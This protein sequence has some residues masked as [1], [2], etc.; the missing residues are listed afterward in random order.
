MAKLHKDYDSDEE[1]PDLSTIISLT[2]KTDQGQLPSSAAIC[3][4][5]QRNISPTRANDKPF[6]GSR[7]LAKQGPAR[8]SYDEKQVRKQR[9]LKAA[10][11]NTLHLPISSG[12]IQTTGTVQRDLDDSDL[13]EPVRPTPRRVA[14]K[15]IDYSA[16]TSALGIALDSDDGHPFDD[17]LDFIV[18]DSDI[19]RDVKPLR[20]PGKDIRRSPKKFSFGSHTIRPSTNHASE[21]EVIDLTSP[22][23]AGR[24][25]SQHESR[26]RHDDA[27]TDTQT[28]G[29]SSTEELPATLRF[30]PPRL[31]SPSKNQEGVRFVTPPGSPFKPRLQS[32]SKQ[33]WIPPSPHRPSIDAFWSQDVINDWNDQYSHKKT[34]KTE[35]R[36]RLF[37]VKEDDESDFSPPSSPRKSGQKTPY[38]KGRDD[39]AKRKEFNLKKHDL[40]TAFLQE[41]DETVANGQ[42]ASMASSAGGIHIVWSKKLNSTAGRANWKR[43]T[44]RSKSADGTVMTTSYRHHASI[45]LAE[46]VIDDEDRLINVLAHEYCHLA[47]FM[48]SGIKDN[49]HGKE[50]KQWAQK[51]THAF[52]HRNIS[53][54]TKHTYTIAYKY[55]WTC[56][57]L[58]CGVEFKRHSKSID[59]A[60]HTC[61]SCKSKL[62]QVLPVPRGKPLQM[63][64]YQMYVREH[65]GR[66]RSE[67]VG[68]GQGEIMRLVG[69][70]FKEMK[71]KA[72]VRGQEVGDE[73]ER[74]E[75]EDD[76]KGGSGDVARKLDFL[77]LKA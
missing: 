42:V 67:N 33:H 39:A 19:E 69:R 51:C 16:F 61:G 38:T 74:V 40:A 26:A 71:A 37:P 77:S 70:G 46:K 1:L 49:P 34:P 21:P 44:L 9:P 32:P 30:S 6:V 10:Q 52:S 60:R 43:E 66:V 36:R 53:V 55:I 62:V 50:F 45:E 11:V 13:E 59:P 12:P 14:K 68:A 58:S 2:R 17:L 29:N 7:A 8:V 23:K 15:Q 65:Y 27:L 35:H 5:A 48:I 72:E 31:R 20:S 63:S 28:N 73:L 76:E 41:L 47:V 3:G 25:I 22:D 24:G 75:V 4:Q 56:T 54:T 57:N 18:R 64:E